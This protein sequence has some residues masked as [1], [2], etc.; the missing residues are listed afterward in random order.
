MTVLY[1][2]MTDLCN[3]SGSA[4][5]LSYGDDVHDAQGRYWECIPGTEASFPRSSSPTITPDRMSV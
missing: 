2:V 4:L 3:M 5:H 1:S